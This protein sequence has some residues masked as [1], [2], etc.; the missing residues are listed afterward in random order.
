MASSSRPICEAGAHRFEDAAVEQPFGLVVRFAL[1][2]GA[3]DA[4]DRLTSE[5][6]EQIRAQEPGTLL[7]AAHRVESD[8]DARLFYELYRDR[9]AFDDHEAQPHTR[10]FLA[11][12]GNYLIRVDVDKLSITV[13]KGI[14]KPEPPLSSRASG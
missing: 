11:E 2:P 14:D 7:Y 9:A 3:G 10:R 4:F 5:T 12:R 13:A 6:V 8:P 1:K